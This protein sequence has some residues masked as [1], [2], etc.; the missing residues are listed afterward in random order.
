MAKK[1]PPARKA[2]EAETNIVLVT[3]LSGAGRTSCLKIF[4]DI[5]F[6]VFDSFPLS[7]IETLLKE[8]AMSDS[9]AFGLDT[10]TRGFA[11]ERLLETWQ[12]LR[13]NKKLNVTLLFLDCDH[14]VLQQRFAD[15][16][17]RHPLAKD[18]SVRDGIKQEDAML[19]PVRAQADMA[20]DTTN[21]STHDLRHVLE[22]QFKHIRARTMTINI[23][24]FAYRYGVPREAD[25]VVDVRFLTN[26]HW[27][28][29][30]R[31]KTGLDKPIGDYIKKDKLWKPFITNLQK[32]L[33][34]LIPAYQREGKNYFTIA[35]GCTGGKHRSVFTSQTL[36]GWVKKAGRQVLVRHRDLE[37][38][39]K[40]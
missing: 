29:K 39:L 25:W 2:E 16:R 1:K 4:E 37:R 18:R 11:P 34:P 20:I 33:E 17:R 30:L 26:P 8:P 14:Q 10:R 5:G 27:E 7:Q 40:R 13:K 9:I 21:L 24:S 15:T 28:P 6:E 12:T 32:T 3:G 36:A 23:M 38:A 35:V 19:F 22:S 31:P